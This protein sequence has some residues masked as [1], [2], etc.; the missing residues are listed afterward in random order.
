MRSFD[1]R[2]AY[3]R[4]NRSYSK[5]LVTQQQFGVGFDRLQRDLSQLLHTLAAY[6]RG[7]C[8]PSVR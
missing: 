8:K 2:Y 7:R 1:E 6:V 3:Y 4:P 5:L